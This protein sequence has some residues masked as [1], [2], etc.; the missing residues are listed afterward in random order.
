ME[1]EVRLSRRGRAALTAATLLASAA[2]L[3]WAPQGA[4]AGGVADLRAMCGT[5]L[6]YQ[7]MRAE[8]H[9]AAAQQDALAGRFEIHDQTIAMAPPVNWRLQSAGSRTFQSEMHNLTFLDGLFFVYRSSPDAATRV[10]ALSQARDLALDWIARNPK[11]GPQADNVSPYAWKNPKVVGDRSGYLA[12]LT[13]AAACEPDVL[14]DA[15]AA[16]LVSTMRRHFLHLRDSERPSNDFPLYMD[17]G[18]AMIADQLPFLEG[19]AEAAPL[20][21]SRF[22][23]GIAKRLGPGGV[24]LEHSVAYHFYTERLLHNFLQ[25]TGTT[26]ASLISASSRM[27]AAA[28]WFVQPDGFPPQWGDTDLRRAPVFARSTTPDGFPGLAPTAAA[29][30]G[31]VRT[32]DSFLGITA[33]Y[34]SGDH[35]HADDGSFDL[36]AAGHRIVSDTGKYDY[37]DVGPRFFALTPQAHSVLTVDGGAFGGGRYGS[38]I[39]GTGTAADGSGWHA[40][41]A[42]NRRLRAQRVSHAR[43]LLYKPGEAVVVVDSARSRAPHV[44]RRYF[45]LGPGIAPAREG[46]SRSFRL[47][48]SDPPFSGL[49]YDAPAGRVDPSVSV[50][51]G[52]WTRD[53]AKRLGFTFP[54]RQ[55]V[56]RS[57]VVYRS[58]AKRVIHAATL[59]LVASQPVFARGVTASAGFSLELSRPGKPKTRLRVE[60]SGVGGLQ[61]TETPVP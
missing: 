50:A 25:H 31:I 18:L 30:Y 26:R 53:P 46:T 21:E 58:R 61:I 7:V 13:R 2:A 55:I 28:P 3:L 51:R 8:N 6:D 27:R 12:Y 5:P 19:A 33:G 60:G 41:I 14:S 38:G 48:A 15:Q 11:S 24:W 20:A 45:Q 54:A 37:S 56:P 35:K 47:S 34:F 22:A 16:T 59:S 10:R 23:A 29:G 49:L 1:G 57:T 32:P 52:R 17:F 39:V 44:Y 9:S 4:M 42:V 43:L 40:I 36:Y